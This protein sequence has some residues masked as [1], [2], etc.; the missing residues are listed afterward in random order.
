M[1]K[2]RCIVPGCTNER[3]SRGVCQSCLRE[4]RMKIR[5]GE[6]TDEQLVAAN[7]LLP[8]ERAGRKKKNALAKALEQAASRK[9]VR[10]GK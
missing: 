6:T 9:A 5:L 1:K 4:A 10:R 8:M 7:L 2:D 3:F